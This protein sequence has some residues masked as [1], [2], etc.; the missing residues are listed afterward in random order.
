MPSVKDK[1]FGRLAAAINGITNVETLAVVSG[2]IIMPYPNAH[3]IISAVVQVTN[4]AGAS[5]VTLKLYRGATLAGTLIMT[6][7]A[8][9]VIAATKSAQA[10]MFQED[11]AN[12]GAQQ[13][14]L[15]VTFSVNQAGNNIDFAD[16]AVT[17]L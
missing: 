12:F 5:T 6:S 3:I 16:I 4:G 14:A 9:N 15:S 13:Y 17:V 1:N 8:L 7:D 2:P 10:L 11:L